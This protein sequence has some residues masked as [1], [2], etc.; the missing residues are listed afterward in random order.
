MLVLLLNN[1]FF[2]QFQLGNLFSGHCSQKS[3]KQVISKLLIKK[4]VGA[5]IF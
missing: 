2:A 5:E 1:Y 3:N 4:T